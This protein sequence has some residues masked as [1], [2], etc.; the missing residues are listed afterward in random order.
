MR[1]F[2]FR[3]STTNQYLSIPI[4]L[5]IGIDCHRLS[6]SSIGYPGS[7]IQYLAPNSFR[8]QDI[9]NPSVR[10]VIPK[11]GWI[12]PVTGFSFPKWG[13]FIPRR[14][15]VFPKCGSWGLFASWAIAKWPDGDSVGAE[16]ASIDNLQLQSIFQNLSLGRSE[17]SQCLCCGK[18][19]NTFYEIHYKDEKRKDHSPS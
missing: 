12:I 1:P 18:L 10:F 19:R 14:E 6:N 11:W 8:K 5:S 17:T 9:F 16:K 4:Y 7:E 3:Q 13:S 15:F 2:R